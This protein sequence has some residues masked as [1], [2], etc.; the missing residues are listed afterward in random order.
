MIAK[1]IVVDSEEDRSYDSDMKKMTN[2]EVLWMYLEEDIMRVQ[3]ERKLPYPPIVPK[4]AKITIRPPK[5][6]N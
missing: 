3:A 6:M 1:M 2:D 4:F 5:R